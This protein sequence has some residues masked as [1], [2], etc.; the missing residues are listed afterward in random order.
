MHMPRSI[1]GQALEE[2]LLELNLTTFSFSEYFRNFY[3]KEASG[4]KK[5]SAAT[6]KTEHSYFLSNAIAHAAPRSPQVQRRIFVGA[7]V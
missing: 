5:Q 4:I 2:S 3:F 7:L 6:F 1:P